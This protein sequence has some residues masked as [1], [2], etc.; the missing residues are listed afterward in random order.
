[1][2]M[3]SSVPV[4]HAIKHLIESNNQL[5][6]QYQQEL[7]NQ[8]A[9]ANDEMMKILNLDPA[10]GWRLDMETMSYVN[11]QPDDTSVGT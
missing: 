5:L 11:V 6:R 9:V 3:T 8:V 2:S 1:M 4:P 7:T 10:N